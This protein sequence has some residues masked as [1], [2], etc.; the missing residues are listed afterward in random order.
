[1]SLSLGMLTVPQATSARAA[2]DEQTTPSAVCES[3][4]V[5]NARG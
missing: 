4:F 2:S 3:E 1:M 5:I